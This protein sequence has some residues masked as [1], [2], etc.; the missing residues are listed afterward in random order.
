ME[1]SMFNI[2]FNQTENQ[3]L[4]HER[5]KDIAPRIASE[6]SYL[7]NHFFLF[8]S[9]TTSTDPKGYAVSEDALLANARAVNEFFELTSSDVWGLTLPWF[10]IGGLSV[11]ARAHLLNAKLVDLTGKWDPHSWVKKLDEEGVTITTVV[12]T[13]IFDIVQN[14]LKAPVQ[15]KYI[16]VGGDFLSSELAKRAIDLGWPVIKTFG[17]TEVCSQLASARSPSDQTLQILP[18]HQIRLDSDQR[19]WVKSQAMYTL[20][21][22]FKDNKVS[23]TKAS[24]RCD[25]DGFFPT[26]DLVQ[27]NNNQ[28]VHLGRIDDQIKI[29]GR[30]T[31]VNTLKDQ[32][33]TYALKHNLY[34]EIELAII[35][36]PRTGKNIEV[37]YTTNDLDMGAL[38]SI[39]HPIRPE[40]RK[41]ESFQ[42]TDLGKLK[43]SL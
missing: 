24:S 14:N 40:F 42:R 11:I 26:N 15:L 5:F 21:F 16:I 20:E 1:G 4:H 22:V 38:K 7:Q 18:I 32:L 33:Y 12:P 36:D 17:M 43:K 34:G 39:Y 10:H 35:D 2:K 23:T 19:L 31:S 28:L 9:G 8:S 37:L 25:K 6:L 13:Q 41:V 3:F 27:W 29:N 30:L